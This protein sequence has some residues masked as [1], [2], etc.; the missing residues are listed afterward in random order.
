[1]VADAAANMPRKDSISSR[2]TQHDVAREAKV[3]QGVV[4]AVLR[5]DRSKVRFSDEVRDRVQAVARRMNYKPDVGAR[6]MRSRKTRTIGLLLSHPK[7][8]P[9]V[10]G[11]I[12]TGITRRAAELGY[13]VSF[14]HD[15]ARL[16]HP[17][18]EALPRSFEE[19]AVDG[20]LVLH[21]GGIAQRL[22]RALRTCGLPIVYLNDRRPSNSVYPDDV[23]GGRLAAEHLLAQGYKRPCFCVPDVPKDYLHFSIGDRFEGFSSVLGNHPAGARKL[24]GPHSESFQDWVEFLRP[25]FLAAPADQRPDMLVCYTDHVALFVA[26]ALHVLGLSIPKDVGL[27]GF[28]DELIQRLAPVRLTTVAVPWLELAETALNRLIQV[29]ESPQGGPFKSLRLPVSLTIRDSSQRRSAR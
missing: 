25:I 5:N 28:N 20:Y 19:L 11:E 29:I 1:M 9:Y 4:S 13:Y 24:V 21:T 26:N 3:S 18:E 16:N 10:P 8:V 23:S 2:C 27:I 12:Y 6:T 17:E 7:D 15:P 22:R 14:I